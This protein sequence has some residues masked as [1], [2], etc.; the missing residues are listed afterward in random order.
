MRHMMHI[1]TLL[2]LVCFA[3]LNMLLF[4]MATSQCKKQTTCSCQLDDWKGSLITLHDLVR[5]T[6]DFYYNPCVDYTI[7]TGNNGCDRVAMCQVSRNSGNGFSLGK[8]NDVQFKYDKGSVF[9]VYENIKSNDGYTRT[10]EIEL[11]CDKTIYGRLEFIVEYSRRG[12]IFKLYSMCA[13]PGRCGN[14]AISSCENIDAC[15]CWEPNAIDRFNLHPL[16]SGSNPMQYKYSSTEIIYYNPC[17]PVISP[18]CLNQSVCMETKDGLVGYGSAISG[19]F[20]DNGNVTLQYTNHDRSSIITLICNK[21]HERLFEIE[22]VD[23]YILKASLTSKCAC[24]ATCHSTISH[25]LQCV[26]AGDGCSCTVK[27]SGTTYD[28]YKLD[29][30][31]SPMKVTD[32]NNHTYYYTPCGGLEYDVIG[33]QGAACQLSPSLNLRP[34]SLG[35]VRPA[36]ASVSS[37][38]G[39]LVIHYVGGDEG[40][41]FDVIIICDLNVTTD[42][43]L[44]TNGVMI[45]EGS[46]HYKFVLTTGEGCP[47]W[48]SD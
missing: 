7:P 24:N 41:S 39:D 21:S 42:P 8:T 15:T 32:Y 12:Y 13:C 16:D 37:S 28:L 23:D 19:T 5:D 44:T 18:Q 25:P 20:V 35:A 43:I 6:Y 33:C 17:S 26:L 4:S 3:I 40:R 30:E 2:L 11:V 47:Q 22:Y 29:K 45:L 36:S 46:L 9:A 31:Y 10:T 34:L 1:C 38:T 27:E 14:S 48:L